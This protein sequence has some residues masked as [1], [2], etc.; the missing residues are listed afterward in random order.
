MCPI[1]RFGVY[2]RCIVMTV[3]SVARRPRL[4]I[5]AYLPSSGTAQGAAFEFFEDMDE[6]LLNGLGVEIVYGD[7]P[8]STYYA[9]E[10]TGDIGNANQAAKKKR[11]P[12]KL[13]AAA[14]D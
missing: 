10:L 3:W 5:A 8:G 2:I 13:L 12:R 14:P 4:S 7:R 1:Q 6:N 11:S 9:A